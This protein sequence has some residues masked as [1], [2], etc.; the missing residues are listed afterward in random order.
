MGKSPHFQIPILRALRKIGGDIKDARKRRRIPVNLIAER[1][2][3]SR[4]TIHKVE[5][6]D[7]GTSFGAYT[8]VLFSLGMIDRLQDIADARH[9]LTG[10]QL[11]DE[12]LPERI[13][14]PKRKDDK[15]G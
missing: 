6:G 4:T 11:L 10:I 8:A 3:L 9:D 1:T 2:G 5:K 14:L 7:P 13:H 12:K 15:H